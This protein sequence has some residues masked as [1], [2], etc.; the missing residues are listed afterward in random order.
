VTRARAGGRSGAGAREGGARR[1]HPEILVAALFAACSSLPDHAR[2]RAGLIDPA[3]Y[4]A[5]DTIAYR[6]LARA[7]FRAAQPPAPVAEH[8]Q[9]FGAFT[10]ANIVPDGMTRVRFDPTG[11]PGT[12][13]ARL[14]NTTFRAEMDRGCSWWNPHGPPIPA[15]Y[16]LQ[17]EQI[18]FALTEIQARRLTAKL[19]DVRLRTGSPDSAASELQ[20]RY[21]RALEEA[22]AELLRTSTAFDEETSGRY[23][24]VRQARWL[25]RVESELARG[26][27]AAPAR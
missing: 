5:T 18:H 16:V 2:P 8:A 10:C 21:N 20:G 25:E 13:L 23:E 26:S 11:E 12:Y 19:R 4:S 27:G 15:D 17:H 24:P 9:S 22:T 3:A 14:E 1:K 6:A 7:D